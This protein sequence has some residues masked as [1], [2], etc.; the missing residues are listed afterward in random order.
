[1]AEDA[2]FAAYNC[3][4]RHATKI[5]MSIPDLN[6]LVTL[7]AVLSEGSVVGAAKR[8]RLSPS[9]MSRALARLRE[10]TGD[11]LLVRAGR[12][13]VPTPRAV[14]L[15]E[16]VSRLVQEAIIVL[17]PAEQLDVRRLSRTFTLRTREGF[18][19]NFGPALIARAAAEAPGVRL[20]FVQKTDKESSA[21]RDGSVDLETGVIGRATS[22][23]IRVQALY[24]DRFIGVVREGHALAKGKVT[25][26]RYAAATHVAVSRPGNLKGPIDDALGMEKFAN[27]RTKMCYSRIEQPFQPGDSND[28]RRHRIDRPHRPGQ[29]VEG[30][31]QHDPRRHP[32]RPR[33]AACD[34]RANIEPGEVEDVLIGCANPEGAT[35]ANIARQ[36]AL[37]GGCPVT[38]AG[39][40]I[41][42]FCSSGLQ[43]IATAAQRIIAGEGDDL[44][45]RRRRV[46]LLRAAGNEHPHAGRSLAQGEQ[47]GTLLADAADRRNRRQALQ[48][49]QA[50]ARTNTACKASSAPPTPR[51]AGRFNAEIVPMTTIMGVADKASGMLL[52]REVTI[53][54]TKASAPTP[55]MKACRRS[56]PRSRRRG[57]R[58]QC[59]PVLG[60]RLGCDRDEQPQGR[61]AA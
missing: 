21:L 27:D 43:T 18:V 51:R 48:H 19:E 47:A 15:R 29:I 12:G 5:P 49:R 35:G 56:A 7:D 38:T 11:P 37:R 57:Q 30:R 55:L 13:L 54:P 46:D 36:I 44:C 40:T 23:E 39:M 41:N 9:A 61:S 28:R 2:A 22:P 20:C 31:L 4:R 6:L 33:A 60:R 24:R 32:G 17:R 25:A 59:Q 26:A 50:T 10:T 34:P 58:R 1:M 53:S 52:T 8:L 14:E 3:T 16:Q 42:R 45:R